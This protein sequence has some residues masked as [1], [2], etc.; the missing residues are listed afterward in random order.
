MIGMRGPWTDVSDSLLG[1]ALVVMARPHTWQRVA[2]SLKRV[3]QVGHTLGIEFDFSE[4]IRYFG[5]GLPPAIL[6]Y[7]ITK[8]LKISSEYSPICQ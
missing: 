2:F 8:V 5:R 3:P 6:D 7:T 4:V 1:V